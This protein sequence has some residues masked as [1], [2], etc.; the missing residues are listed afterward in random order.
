ME[1]QVDKI[2]HV[3]YLGWD[4]TLE[5]VIAQVKRPETAASSQSRR[6]G[7]PERI[8]AQIQHPEAAE[9]AELQRDLAD[10]MVVA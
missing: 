9:A 6:N 3:A 1:E 4:L 7:S 5:P 2:F 10:E 8:S